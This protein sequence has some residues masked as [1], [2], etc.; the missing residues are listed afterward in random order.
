M[1][2]NQINYMY[3]INSPSSQLGFYIAGLIEGDGN[4]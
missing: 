2:I 4:I 1:S 3:S